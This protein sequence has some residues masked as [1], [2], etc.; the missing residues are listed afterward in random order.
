MRVKYRFSWL[1]V[2]VAIISISV[3]GSVNVL[4]GNSSA[5]NAKTLIRQASTYANVVQ[6]DLSSLSATFGTID[7]NLQGRSGLLDLIHK[8]LGLLTACVADPQD[9]TAVCEDS[10]R[11]R[12]FRKL[13]EQARLDKLGALAANIQTIK[14]LLDKTSVSLSALIDRIAA[15]QQIDLINHNDVQFLQHNVANCQKVMTI[16]GSDVDTLSDQLQDEDAAE[17]IAAGKADDVNEFLLLALGDANVTAGVQTESGHLQNAGAV[18]GEVIRSNQDTRDSI[19][20]CS[21]LISQVG[22][23]LRD[24]RRFCTFYKCSIQST[25]LSEQSLRLEGATSIHAQI[26]TLGGTLVRETWATSDTLA[27]NSTS[28]ANGAYL[29]VVTGVSSDGQIIPGKV[30][31]VVIVH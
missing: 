10:V 15:L 25:A 19:Q 16:I 6:R 14:H 28:L 20:V 18:L 30:R 8:A 22:S 5:Q 1:I 13:L 27:L 7:I 21:S 3:I 17:D 11:I 23:L 24:L 31:K 9:P 26:Y 12:Q 29:V 2:L 4:A